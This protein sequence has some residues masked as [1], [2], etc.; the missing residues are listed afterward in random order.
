MALP[1][2]HDLARTLTSWRIDEIIANVTFADVA[3]PSAVDLLHLPALVGCDAARQIA[4]FAGR[5][6][7]HA[8][9]Q[10]DRSDKAGSKGEGHLP[11]HVASRRN[12]RAL[13]ICAASPFFVTPDLSKMSL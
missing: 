4:R 5:F 1:G 12:R 7:R 6:G 11:F 8:E 13:W 3:N 2:D 9:T 10:N